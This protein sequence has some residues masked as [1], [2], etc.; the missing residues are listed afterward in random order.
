MSP[1]CEIID[2]LKAH[3]YDL[4]V[5][6]HTILL[7]VMCILIDF[8]LKVMNV[9]PKRFM[10]LTQDFVMKHLFQKDVYFDTRPNIFRICM[11]TH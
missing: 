9:V 4:Y 11:I 1:Y 10:L 5:I 8:C 6:S 7:Y 3:L 2:G